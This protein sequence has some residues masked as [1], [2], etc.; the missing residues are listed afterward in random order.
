[1][2]T[3]VCS[4]VVI[5]GLR[6]W[7]RGAYAEEAAVELLVRAFGG[8]FASTRYRWV[9]ACDRPG[10]YWLDGE[11]LIDSTGALSGG[12]RR[13]L[14]IAGSLVSGA[15]LTDLDGLLTGLDRP[16]LELVLAALA[17]AA[18]SHEQI[19]ARVEG[20]LL[21]YRRLGPVLAWPTQARAS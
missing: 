6:R 13:V 16:N 15:S 18:G 7:A 17:H 3:A 20:D 2:A 10:W 4:T 9:R 14:T 12:E 5:D 8:R 1:M 11:R 21:V 19:A